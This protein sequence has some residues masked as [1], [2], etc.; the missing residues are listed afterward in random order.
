[1]S[2]TRFHHSWDP[3]MDLW[4]H[5]K[6]KVERNQP[7]NVQ[8]RIGWGFLPPYTP[9]NESIR[10]GNKISV[11]GD[12][13]SENRICSYKIFRKLSWKILSILMVFLSPGKSYVFEQFWTK[14]Y[15]K[16]WSVL[17]VFSWKIVCVLA[18]F[19]ESSPMEILMCSSTLCLSCKI[20]MCSCAI[21]GSPG[22]FGVF[23]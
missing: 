17:M 21:F 11:L 9:C 1:M 10:R 13:G 15:W 6:N 18:E 3:I 19:W 23:L 7:M 2:L 5:N 8:F 4:R 12:M 22:I 16:I 14:I 20:Y